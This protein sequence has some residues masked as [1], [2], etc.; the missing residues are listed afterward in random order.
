VTAMYEPIPTHA[1]YVKLAGVKD[2]AMRLTEA[3]T[4]FLSGQTEVVTAVFSDHREKPEFPDFRFAIIYP[5]T[6]SGEQVRMD[7][8]TKVAIAERTYRA[9]QAELSQRFP[10]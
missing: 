7:L 9:R 10:F 6:W 5:R 8:F 3:R 4:T 2:D 1:E